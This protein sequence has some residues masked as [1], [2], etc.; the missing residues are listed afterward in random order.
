MKGWSDQCR[1]SI[2][3]GAYRAREDY[4]REF[5]DR[6]N[7]RP[8]QSAVFRGAGRPNV[9]A[10]Y[11]GAV[12]D[13]RRIALFDSSPSRGVSIS[14]VLGALPRRRRTCSLRVG[15]EQS[16]PPTLCEVSSS[17]SLAYSLEVV[18]Q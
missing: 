7:R 3:R 8:D 11:C 4:P 15:F 12:G 9:L 17:R 16:V 1:S 18:L 10:I 13:V 2:E 5:P 6:T 14:P